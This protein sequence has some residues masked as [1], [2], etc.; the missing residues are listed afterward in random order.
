MKEKI[1]GVYLITNNLNGMS[2]AGQSKNCWYRWTIHKAQS[3]NRA[4]IDIAINEFG[5]ENFTFKIEKE[6]LPEELDFYEREAIKKYN[7]LWPNGY[8]RYTGGRGDFGICEEAR[9][10]M[11]I[12][13]KNKPPITE[14]TRKKMSIS[15]KNKPPMSNEAKRKI[16]ESMT[17]KK[18]PPISEE[19]RIKMSESAKNRFPF[20][21]EHRRHM[22]ESA[23]NRLKQK[24]ITPDGE[25]R[26]MSSQSAGRWHKDWIRIEE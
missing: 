5:A 11:S 25:I 6:C 1:C 13:Q 12:S 3:R 7:T 17:G 19:T 24:W 2:Y 15:Q 4:P 21:E 16:S 9:K 26:E 18:K 23:K 14:E 8:N 20:T 22:S 10:K